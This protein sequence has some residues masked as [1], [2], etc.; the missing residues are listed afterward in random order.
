MLALSN[1]RL[2][3]SPRPEGRSSFD[4]VL[5]QDLANDQPAFRLALAWAYSETGRD[6]DIPRAQ[7]LALSLVPPSPIAVE[8]DS[9]E[10]WRAR[11]IQMSIY[12]S[13]AERRLTEGT[14]SADAKQYL[15]TA[16]EVFQALA[17]NYPDLGET[18]VPGNLAAWLEVL[19]RLNG[20]RGR[21]GLPAVEV[22][23]AGP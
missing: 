10:F 21:A 7:N 14:T 19:K 2:E 18:I 8:D 20:L 3:R 1:E 9:E 15:Q 4:P 13:A 5:Y 23:V 12:L 16:G 17:A 22:S 6:E 11:A